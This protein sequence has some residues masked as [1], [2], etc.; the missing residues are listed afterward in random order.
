MEGI[1]QELSLNG[2]SRMQT[3]HAACL[4]ARLFNPAAVP[5][6]GFILVLRILLATSVIRLPIYPFAG[7]HYGFHAELDEC[8]MKKSEVNNADRLNCRTIT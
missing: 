8:A 6:A 1:L 3:A 7:I 2:N 4:V 5:A